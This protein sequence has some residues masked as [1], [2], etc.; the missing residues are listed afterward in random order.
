MSKSGSDFRERES[1]SF[2]IGISD[3]RSCLKGALNAT[4][5]YSYK[6]TVV[7]NQLNIDKDK[8]HS[9]SLRPLFLYYNCAIK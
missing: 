8:T 5:V 6:F 2:I 7:D 4:E 9:L 1:L 3:R